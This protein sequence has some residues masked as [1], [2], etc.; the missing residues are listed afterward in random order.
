MC[1]FLCSV[2]LFIHGWS[3]LVLNRILSDYVAIGHGGFIDNAC[4]LCR[5]AGVLGPEKV[6]WQICTASL[7]VT[8]HTALGANFHATQL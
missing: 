3:R 6:D 4:V 7:P 8:C 1:V 2:W 5:L